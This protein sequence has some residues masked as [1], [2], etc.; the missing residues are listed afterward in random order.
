MAVVVK[1]NY[2]SVRAS[3]VAASGGILF[4]YDMGIISGALLQLRTRFNMTCL[5]EEL[6]VSCVLFGALLS[7]LLGGSVI[8]WIGRKLTMIVNCVLFIIGALILSIAY[9]F[10]S[11]II[12][13]VLLGLAVGLSA[14]AECAYISEIASPEHRGKLVSLNEV[15]I[16]VGFLLAYL[17][18]Y[19]CISVNNGWRIMFGLSGLLALFQCVALFFVPK[20]PRFLLVKDARDEA[21]TVLAKLRGSQ[22]VAKAELSR[23]QN[24]ISAEKGLGWRNIF[25]LKSGMHYRLIIGLGLV[26]AQQFS[27]LPSVLYYSP[28]LLQQMGFESNESATLASIGAGA[29]KAVAVV[30]SLLLVDKVGRK[31]LLVTGCIVM[32]I[33]LFV[34]AQLNMNSLFTASARCQ[35][36]SGDATGE[37]LHR[38]SSQISQSYSTPSKIASLISMLCYAAA[39]SL[40][41]GPVTWLLLSEIFPS[42]VK[43]RAVA[44]IGAINWS[45][46]TLVSFTLLDYLDSVGIS[47]VFIT[48]GVA[49]LLGILFILLIVPETRGQNL[50]EI[51]H[52]LNT[53]SLVTEI[54][55]CAGLSCCQGLQRSTSYRPLVSGEIPLDSLTTLNCESISS[56]TADEHKMLR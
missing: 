51:N 53:M 13:R 26:V 2:L 16:A 49:C 30:A 36:I 7:S 8:D 29:T 38:N 54:K 48:Y 12:G 55:K 3:L 35:N 43:G 22:A 28:Q 37:S 33:S 25:S 10:T 34:M 31:K 14:V 56:D 46:N 24:N 44:F 21:L 47:G 20:T 50:E 42:A 52:L 1:S 45:I 15:A 5:Q 27:G 41:Y 11:L 39:Y 17:V 9:S 40:G 32:A 18:N 4:G 19:L 23:I 6:L